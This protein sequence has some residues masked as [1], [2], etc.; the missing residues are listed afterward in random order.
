MAEKKSG[1]WA[2]FD[3]KTNDKSK[4][5]CKECNAVL[6]RGKPDNPKSFSTSSLITHLR[7]KHPLQ[8]HNMNSLKS[9]IAEDPAT[10]WKF[11]TTKYPTIS[12]VAQVYLAPPT[13]VPSE[14]LFSTAGDIITEHRTR[15]L[16]DNAEKL[17][18]LKYNASLI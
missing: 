6:S 1:L 18:F 3:V 11:N 17:I 16:P 5:V 14:R 13:S 4:A 10:W 2:F 12:K 9:S 15:L 7:S 8:Y